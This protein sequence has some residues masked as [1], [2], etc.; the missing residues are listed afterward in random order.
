MEEIEQIRMSMM[1]ME[2]RLKVVEADRDEWKDKA[3]TLADNFLKT[4]KDLKKNLYAVKKDH[5]S[6]ILDARQEFE[7]KILVLA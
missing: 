3:K 2:E 7:Q 6:E 5:E 4:M 1:Q